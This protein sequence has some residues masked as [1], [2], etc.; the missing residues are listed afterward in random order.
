[1]FLMVWA[2]MGDTVD[3]VVCR[4]MA[5]ILLCALGG[6]LAPLAPLIHENMFIKDSEVVVVVAGC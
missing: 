6:P 4:V 3:K 5:F 1:M 2:D